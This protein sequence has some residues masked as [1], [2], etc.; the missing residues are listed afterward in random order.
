MAFALNEGRLR[1]IFLYED[2]SDV[3]VFMHVILFLIRNYNYAYLAFDNT[4]IAETPIARW[5][6]PMLLFN[7]PIEL[8]WDFCP[9]DIH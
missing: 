5:V 3:T 6:A 2:R 4:C 7:D 9:Q 8:I 1:S